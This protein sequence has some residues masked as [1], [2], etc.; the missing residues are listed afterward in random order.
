[1]FQRGAI[2]PSRPLVPFLEI[3]IFLFHVRNLLAVLVAIGNVAIWGYGLLAPL[4]P[5]LFTCDSDDGDD[6]GAQ[7][8]GPQYNILRPPSRL[9][10]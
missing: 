7:T 9:R 1:M 6:L 8:Y 5:S 4:D 3:I 2:A 10:V